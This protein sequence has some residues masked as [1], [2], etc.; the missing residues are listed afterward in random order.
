M[1][2]TDAE[3]AA[4]YRRRKAVEG[5][6][7]QYFGGRQFLTIEAFREALPEFDDEVFWESL[8]GLGEETEQYTEERNQ[9][10][11]DAYDAAWQEEYDAAWQEEYD[12]LAADLDEDDDDAD[13]RMEA[14]NRAKEAADEPAREAADE[15]VREWEAGVEYYHET[16]V[17]YALADLLDAHRAALGVC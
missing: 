7:E 11:Q 1:A 4:A 13:I 2:K 12:E 17:D 10:W 14:G 9:V 6:A 8:D 15:A 5:Y 16:C 3:R